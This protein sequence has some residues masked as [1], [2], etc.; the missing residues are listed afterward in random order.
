[1]NKLLETSLELSRKVC[2]RLHLQKT[3]KL[4]YDLSGQVV[5]DYLRDLLTADKPCMI[6]RLGATELNYLANYL[7]VRD[8]RNILVKL[9]KYLTNQ[10]EEFWWSAERRRK[11][12]LWSGFFPSDQDKLSKFAELMLASLPQIDMLGSWLPE[13]RYFAKELR[14]AKKVPL[15]DLEPYYHAEPWTIA[16]RGKK[17]LVV[18]PFSATI[19]SQYQK[20]EKLFMNPDVLPEFHLET[21]QAVQSI[22]GTQTKYT[23]WFAALDDMKKQIALKDFD[24][25]ILGCGAYG[26]PLAAYIKGLGK[27][28]VHL[29]GCSQLLFGIKGKRFD[30]YLYINLLYN[31]HWVRPSAEETPPRAE[32]VEGGCYW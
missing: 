10:M 21:I 30:P 20:R 16:L 15:I 24:V 23:D 1:M 5:S 4:S 25:A 13:E 8:K 27:K 26:F 31:K 6:A 19:E 28:A 29:G 9:Y 3:Y 14:G 18:H 7:S 12:S 2:R 11:M 17:V 22:A 32:I